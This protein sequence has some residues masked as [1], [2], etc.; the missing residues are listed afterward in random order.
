MKKH[1]SGKATLVLLITIGITLSFL[2]QG[3]R[4]KEV[5]HE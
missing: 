1:L 3:C 5:K 4:E 2:V